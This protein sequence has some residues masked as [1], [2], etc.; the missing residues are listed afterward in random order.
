MGLNIK[1]ILQLGG[2][3]AATVATGGIAAPV[4]IGP[5]L[6]L[7]AELI[8]E[9]DAKKIAKE[10]DLDNW[11]RIMIAEWVETYKR[12]MSRNIGN[13][14]QVFEGYLKSKFIMN[15]ADNPKDEWVES[16]HEMVA[17][18]VRWQIASSG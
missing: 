9:K 14:A 5:V 6:N 17:E 15:Y 11:E 16:V 7:A 2:G 12:L 18:A 8:P 13:L 3:I 10:A 1:K 4:L